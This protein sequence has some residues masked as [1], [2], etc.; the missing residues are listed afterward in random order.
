MFSPVGSN[1]WAHV[2]E[3]PEDCCY[4]TWFEAL[5]FIHQCYLYDQKFDTVGE[6]DYMITIKNEGG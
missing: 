1:D 2:T 4:D 5:V 6:Y 3:D